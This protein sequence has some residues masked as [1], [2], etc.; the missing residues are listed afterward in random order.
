MPE[1][2]DELIAAIRSLQDELC[3]L[4]VKREYINFRRLKDEDLELELEAVSDQLKTRKR[5]LGVKCETSG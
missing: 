4:K 5:F 2:R 3:E 1:T